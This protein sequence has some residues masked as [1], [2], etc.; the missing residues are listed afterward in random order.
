M[1]VVYAAGVL[2]GLVLAALQNAAASLN[3]A[4]VAA[5]AAAGTSVFIDSPGDTSTA[6]EQLPALLVRSGIQIKRQLSKGAL[7]FESTIQIA[8]QAQLVAETEQLAQAQIEAMGSVIEPALLTDPVLSG[9]VEQWVEL[10]E[11]VTITSATEQHNA[12]LTMSVGMQI[13]EGPNW[14]LT[15]VPLTEIQVNS[16][17]ANPDGSYPV[18]SV[19]ITNLNS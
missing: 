17:A 3:A 18:L 4:L 16:T 13:A 6:P 12:E 7:I 14:G 8:L 10:R 1:P 15:G 5:G 19:D 2:R 9:I 11:E